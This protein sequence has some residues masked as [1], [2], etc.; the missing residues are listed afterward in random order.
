M[1][2]SKDCRVQLRPETHRRISH[3]AIE[4]EMSI[5]EYVDALL[6]KAL[7]TPTSDC[8]APECDPQGLCVSCWSRVSSDASTTLRTSM[9]RGRDTAPAAYVGDPEEDDELLRDAG[10]TY[11]PKGEVAS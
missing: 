4:C 10:V 1:S 11:A 6:E 9:P 7:D 8:D 2:T 3:L 5:V